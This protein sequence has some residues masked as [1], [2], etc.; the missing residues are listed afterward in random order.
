MHRQA[1]RE[2]I[3]R[4]K[5]H[6]CVVL[7][8]IANE[9]ESWTPESRAYF[10]PLV[11]E[12]RRLDPTRP[13]AFANF[14]AATPDRDVISDLFDVLMLN[15]YYGWYA[16]TGDLAAAERSLEEELRA[17]VDKHD[18]PIIFT[19][20]GADAVAGLH[21]LP[22]GPVDGGV[23]GGRA[24]D[25]PPR[26]RPVRRGRRRADLELR[27]LRHRAGDHARR[28][29]QEGRLHPRAPAEGRRAHAAAALARAS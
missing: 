19:E 13:V 24:R 12:T 27:R 22:P 20:Y 18:K 14:M 29:Q 16:Q 3:A 21:A 10:E 7:W 23:P 1:I 26:L 15:R 4:D 11:A 28:R 8:S 5:N 25:V 9:P 6:P 2:L 17:W